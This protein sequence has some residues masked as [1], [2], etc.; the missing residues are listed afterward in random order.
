MEDSI[1]EAVST[2]P[3]L[4]PD[5]IPRLRP[6]I[7]PE[8]IPNSGGLIPLT[9]AA[10]D[11]RIRIPALP[12]P[13]PVGSRPT[14]RIYA[15]LR[16]SG[17]YELLAH[18]QLPA[19]PAEDFE[20]LV[21]R[22]KVG[23]EGLY[24]LR[25]VM[26]DGNNSLSST[27]S[28]RLLIQKTA[29]FGYLTITPPRPLP[30]LNLPTLLITEKYLSANDPV[31][32]RVAPH[33]EIDNQEGLRCVPYYGNRDS[34][35]QVSYAVPPV[36][37]LPDTPADRFIPVPAATI[38]ARGNGLQQLAIRY[39]DRAGNRARDT[40]ILEVRV[41]LQIT[42]SNIPVPR[43]TQAI[44]PDNTV[45]LADISPAGMEVWLD[46]V[47]G[48]QI[49]NSITVLIGTLAAVTVPYAGQPLPMRLVVPVAR[50]QATVP[51]ATTNDTPASVSFRITNGGVNFDGRVARNLIFNLST[52]MQ[53]L[54]PEVRN[55]NDGNLNCN[56]PQPSNLP[57][58]NRFIEVFIPPSPLLRA[59]ATVTVNCALSR[60]DDG[61]TLINP[62]VTVSALLSADAAT[63]GQTLNVPYSSTMGLIG[64][65]VIY[66]FYM[67]L[68]AAGQLIR[69]APVAVPVRGVL[70]GNFYCDGTPFIPEP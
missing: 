52:F 42:P 38:R 14:I 67:T 49:G 2:S 7:V 13:G 62:P 19:Y 6:L 9:A 34:H 69:S 37:T 55:L 41:A 51:G 23:S 20:V 21:D 40:L 57:Y 58:S 10:R 48:L 59:N 64:R 35:M 22:R 18:H 43:V 39:L 44:A 12:Q 3:A 46:S 30:P 8:A 28:T 65:G 54:P 66:F 63:R 26:Y 17:E 53:L 4:N 5:P 45:T 70:P 1:I 56:S 60:Q 15:E 32:F 25:Y 68:N 36:M 27:A 11:L 61:S 31:M 47:D 24:L 33:P 16:S 50:V 29:P